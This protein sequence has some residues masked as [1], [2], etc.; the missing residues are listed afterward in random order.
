M[1][2]PTKAKCR[3][4]LA[5]FAP[6]DIVGRRHYSRECPMARF[7]RWTF[8]DMKATAFVLP[9]RLL[10]YDADSKHEIASARLPAWARKIVL[11]VDL[12]RTDDP[13]VTAA[14]IAA[15]LH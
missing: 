3:E 14:E 7:V 10:V 2:F 12:K 1:R 13:K 9:P 11:S 4:W 6:T 15:L 5:T 8:G